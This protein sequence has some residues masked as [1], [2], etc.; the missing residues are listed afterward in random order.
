MQDID[1]EKG[2]LLNNFRQDLKNFILEQFDELIKIG[3]LK[4]TT[5]SRNFLKKGE[6]FDLV[7]WYIYNRQK[8]PYGKKRV[9]F[10]KEIL[11]SPLYKAFKKKIDRIKTCFENGG[12]VLQFLTERTNHLIFEDKLLDDWGIIYLH[13][14]PVNERNSNNDNLLLFVYIQDDNVFFLN[15][16][17]HNSFADIRLLEIID[18][19]WIGLLNICN[20]YTPSVSTEQE[21]L[22]LRKY[23]I[24][25]TLSVNGKTVAT[26]M[27]SMQKRT[28]FPIVI[29]RVLED[30]V[31]L[32]LENKSNLTSAIGKQDFNELDIHIGFD[33]EKKQVIIYDKNSE[34]GFNIDNVE[35]FV[36][37]SNILRNCNIF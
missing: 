25:Y 18:N 30:I 16:G 35:H 8:I 13:L 11:K 15:I 29:N 37:F 28:M 36:S 31:K 6:C 24:A 1:K 7:R 9:Y 23:K 3:G 33:S 22:D 21:I 12:D 10:S 32:V 20:N 5:Q 4:I 34:T 17:N 19:N 27:D 2:I 26:Q 14:H